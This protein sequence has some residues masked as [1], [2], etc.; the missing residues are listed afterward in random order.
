ML[1]ASEAPFGGVAVDDL[2]DLPGVH[3]AE[4]SGLP[5]GRRA[6]DGPRAAAD[7][8]DGLVAECVGQS[9]PRVL[10][11]DDG[12]VRVEAAD[13]GGQV[14]RSV[15]PAQV[16]AVGAGSGVTARTAHQRSHRSQTPPSMARVGSSWHAEI[17]SATRFTFALQ[18]GHDVWHRDWWG[19]RV[20]VPSRTGPVGTIARSAADARSRD[21]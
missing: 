4:G 9:V 17:A 13:R 19:E 21:R 18:S 1:A 20:R 11:G 7:G 8:L 2:D 14:A 12:A 16:A 3:G 15:S 10:E 6:G 5:S